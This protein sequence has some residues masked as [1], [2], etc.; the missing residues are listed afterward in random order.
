MKYLK[1]I[2]TLIVVIYIAYLSDTVYV[3]QFKPFVQQHE[4]LTR[5][6]FTILFGVPRLTIGVML[7]HNLDRINKFI[8]SDGNNNK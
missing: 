6:L 2:A 4:G 1:F 3:V 7:G 8:W 5:L